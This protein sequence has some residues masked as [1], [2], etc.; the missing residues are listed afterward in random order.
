MMG[1]GGCD[2]RCVWGCWLEFPSS[3]EISYWCC[4]GGGGGK[5]GPLV[6]VAEPD[7]FGGG[8]GGVDE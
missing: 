5:G 6:G 1:M 7:G 2:D 4:P 8:T 3:S